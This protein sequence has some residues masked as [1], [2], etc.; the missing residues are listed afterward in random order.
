MSTELDL[1]R[2]AEKQAEVVALYAKATTIPQIIKQTQLSKTIVEQMLAEYRQYAL[3]D[4]SI[5][6]KSREAILTTREHYDG[7]IRDIYEAIEK[8]KIEGALEF[9]AHVSALKAIGDLENQRISFMQK[10]GMLVDNEIGEQLAEA[11]RKHT[12]IIDILKLISRKH[13]AVAAEIQDM[14]GQVTGQVEGVVVT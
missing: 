11:E 4:R 5:Q 3:Q 13:P 12:I 14:L 10:A 9:K 6:E 8:A 2:Y 7:L 1:I